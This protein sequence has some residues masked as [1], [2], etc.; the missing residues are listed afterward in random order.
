[1]EEFVERVSKLGL[2][3]GYTESNIIAHIR[4]KLPQALSKFLLMSFKNIQEFKL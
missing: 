3:I 2:A 1:M 4:C